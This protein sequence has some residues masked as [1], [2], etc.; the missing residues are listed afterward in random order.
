LKKLYQGFHALVLLAGMT[1]PT[2]AAD[3]SYTIQLMTPE[4]ALKAAMA[5]LKECRALGYQISIAVVDRTGQT[6]VVL[7]DR[8]AGM[9][10]IEAATNKAWTAVSFKTNT[11]QFAENTQSGKESSGIRNIPKV[12][13]IGGGMMVDVGGVLFGGIGVSGAPNG[14]AD[15]K[16]VKAAI[17]SIVED[18]E[19]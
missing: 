9:H 2:F 3:A 17:A 7:R 10:T 16:C 12:L 13:A 15:D 6:Q 1:G 18:L 4:T 5:G 19:L 11:S 8:F 14:A